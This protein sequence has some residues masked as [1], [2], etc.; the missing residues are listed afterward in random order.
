MSNL[1]RWAVTFHGGRVEWID[2]LAG[3][4]GA[5]ALAHAGIPAWT[6]ASVEKVR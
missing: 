1:E 2:V 3:L 4:S 6:V 5:Q